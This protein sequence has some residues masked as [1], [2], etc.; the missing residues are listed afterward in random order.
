[1]DIGP[2]AP[3]PERRVDL[4]AAL[5]VTAVATLAYVG[6]LMLEVV[7]PAGLAVAFFAAAPICALFATVVLLARAHAEHDSA[8]AWFGSGLLVAWVAMVLQLISFPAVTEGGG[9]F[10]TSDQSSATL[11]LFFHLA[12]AAAA[13]AGALNAPMGWRRPAIGVGVLLS[14]LIAADLV[15]LPF[16]LRADAT[17]TDLLVGIEYALAVLIAAAAVIW[18]RQVGRAAPALRGWVGVGLSLSV[19]DVLLN[20][21]AAERFSSVWWASLSLRVATYAVLAMGA[22]VTLLVRLR[23]TESYTSSELD[24]REDELRTSLRLTSELLSCAEDLSRAVTP[25][26]VADALCQ[27]AVA[28][29]GLSHATLMVDRPGEGL[30]PL[31]RVGDEETADAEPIGWE[32]LEAGRAGLARGLAEFLDSAVQIREKFPA[33]VR[34]TLGRAGTLAV[35]PIRIGDEPVGILVAWD[36]RE[37]SLVRVQRE[38]LIGIAA[39]GGQALRRAL[40]F[41]N[42]ANAAATLQLSL[43][44]GGLPHRDELSMAARYV[45]GQQGLRVGGDWYDC[46]VVDDRLVALVVGDVMGKGLRAATVMGQ[47]R[48]AVRSLAGADP[49]PAAVLTGLDRLSTTLHTNEIATLVYVLL[50][51]QAGTAKVARAGH[52]PP[53]LVD[54]EGR[55][56]FIEAGASPPLGIPSV[57]RVEATVEVPAGSL[58]VLYT[59]GI[60]EDRPTG[61]DRLET[62]RTMV[63]Q[64]VAQNPDDLEAVATDV[65]ADAAP[66]QRGDDIALLLARFAGVDRAGLGHAKLAAAR[67]RRGSANG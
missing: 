3:K 36:E 56:T 16:L 49:S 37:R 4:Y 17:F 12:P 62:F 65:L 53:I 42:E 5:L 11:Y 20:A 39:Q 40:A 58:L 46:V 15:P 55:A 51:V 30:V 18:V 38:V 29:S 59:D 2:R 67:L 57:E 60:V 27:D 9:V 34:T 44:S 28:A 35:L 23:E 48:T 19:Y 8:L 10:G 52:L 6:A 24:R 61:L 1:M 25:V 7:P 31:G 13:V 63:A 22:V 21:F 41:E 54:P 43:L 45:A 47:M 64:R 14:F 32:T 26:E 50:D 33:A 66:A